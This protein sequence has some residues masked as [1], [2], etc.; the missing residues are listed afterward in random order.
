MAVITLDYNSEGLRALQSQG[1]QNFD[2]M[3]LY[4]RRA[5]LNSAGKATTGIFAKSSEY[6]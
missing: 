6:H 1:R 4:D 3:L 2:I 5:A